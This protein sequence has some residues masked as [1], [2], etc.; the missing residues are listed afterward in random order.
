MDSRPGFLKFVA[1][2]QII[3]IIL[4][5]LGHS[6]HMY[7]DGNHGHSTLLYRMLF[8]FRM[9]LFMF[10][11]G[12]L[13]ILTTSLRPRSW[14]E[15]A[16]GKVKRLLIPFITLTAVVFIPRAAMSSLADDA[17]EL[18]PA[19]FVRA[20]L[21][22]DDLVIPYLWFLHSSFTMLLLVYAVVAFGRVRGIAPRFYLPALATLFAL[23]PLMPLAGS[24]FFSLGETVRL[25]FYF[26]LG[27]IY[28]QWHRQID[29]AIPWEHPAT[30]I[31]A[32]AVWVALF[33]IRDSWGYAAGLCC[34]TAGIMMTI[35]LA[36][37]IEKR[38]LTF[39]DHLQG[40]NYMIFL[41]SWFFNVAAQQVLA[42]YV[43]LPWYV[44]TVLSLLLG[45][46]VPWLFY[47]YM[48]KHLDSR[49]MRSCAFFL[50]QSVRKKTG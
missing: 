47:R 13:L 23:L 45:I 30:F 6:C 8:S 19:R 10:T 46:Y 22:T 5:V 15:F 38:H 42:H 43:S 50:G 9:P 36:K 40:A 4:V 31:T 37:I 27:T 29:K 17:I 11:S 12:F 26:V 1:Y 24:S 39:L 3:G 28:A 20:F 33:F 16:L 2:L 25:G 18:S 49:T 41:L 48:I 14:N 21:Y 44:H 7:P 34:S 35:S 32:A